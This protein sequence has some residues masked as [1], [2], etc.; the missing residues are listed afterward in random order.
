M[1]YCEPT[2]AIFAAL[3]VPI[4]LPEDC[5]TIDG[6]KYKDATVSRVEP[7]GLVSR[8]KSGISKV[9]FTELP[10]EIQERFNYDRQKGTEY[11]SQTI[12]EIAKDLQRTGANSPALIR[13]RER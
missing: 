11:A 5:K 13:S 2:I 9:Y 1:K 8:T 10:K 7:D 6:K 12:E 4:G 3:F